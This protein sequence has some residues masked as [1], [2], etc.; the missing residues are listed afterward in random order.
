MRRLLPLLL[1]AAVL[2][3]GCGSRARTTA[4]SANVQPGFNGNAVVPAARG[5]ASSQ[6]AAPS[7]APAA[8]G[9]ALASKG[10]PK[11]LP[12]GPARTNTM[13]LA[14]TMQRSCGVPG[15]T[16]SAKAVTV[17]GASLSFA[18][19]YSDNSLPPDFHYV[20]FA[21]NTSGSFTW[22]WVLRP[23]I[24]P[25]DALLVVVAAKGN[26][27]ASFNLPFRVARAC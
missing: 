8:T 22:T 20:A 4:N 14:V 18:A 6:S 15:D 25:G 2:A 1:A 24:P 10:K 11:A 21:E 3:T 17:P 9:G 26:R 16:M 5:G 7:A 13:P 19:A 27:G 12:S 23:T